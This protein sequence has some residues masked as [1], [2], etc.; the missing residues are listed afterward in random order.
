SRSDRLRTVEQGRCG[1]MSAP[2]TDDY[3]IGIVQELRKLP[4]E[5]EWAE[6][7]VNKEDPEEI[8][9]YVS[10][11]ANSAAIAGKTR[12]YLV[13]GVEDGT[14][15]V[16]G[17]TFSPT[18]KTVG[19]EVFENWLLRLLDPKVDFQFKEVTVD[20]ERVVLLAIE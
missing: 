19:N 6:F 15:D 18:A 4:A 9:R 3:A 11:L 2:L 13:W 20:G 12:G 8:G 14:H 1:S 7:K 5:T 17:T 16:V 10:A